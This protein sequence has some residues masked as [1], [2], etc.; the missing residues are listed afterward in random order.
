MV[1]EPQSDIN[2]IAFLDELRAI[3]DGCSG[4]LLLCGDFNL[5]YKAEDKNNSILNR[6]MMGRFRRF[7]DDTELQELH[8]NGRRFT[9]SNER[10]NP[11]LE[12][13]D[14]V[15]ASEDWM[16]LYPNH[17]LSALA[18][19]CSDHAPLR[20]STATPLHCFKRFHFENFWPKFDGF[21]QVVEEAWICHGG[22][23]MPS[24]F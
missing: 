11:M 6:R 5:I 19:E 20:L 14:R 22:T 16:L 7:I 1:G 10:D 18:S 24:A 17:V 8:L 13:L 23:Q 15:F 9:W 2:K 21:M 12:R 3:R 4:P